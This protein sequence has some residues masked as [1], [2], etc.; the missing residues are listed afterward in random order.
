M[1]IPLDELL[2]ATRL[3]RGGRLAEATAAIQRALGIGAQKTA[4]KD[5]DVIDMPSRVVGADGEL[6]HAQPPVQDKP[7]AE[8]DLPS[9]FDEHSFAFAGNRYAYRLFVPTGAAANAPLPLV[10]MLHGCKQDAADFAAGTQMNA[11]GEQHKF[12]VLYPEQL[13]KSNQMGC[14]NWFEPAHQQR[15]AGEPAMIA[16]LTR[17][18]VAS[19]NADPQRVYVAGLSAGGAMA[20]LVGQLY[21]DVFAAVGV[22]SGLAPGAAKDVPSAFTAMRKGGAPSGAKAAPIPPT[23]VIHGSADKT[24]HPANS[25]Q[26]AQA[27]LASLRAA[28][29]TLD[30]TSSDHSHP[31]RDAVRTTYTA[32]DGKPMLETWRVDAAPHAWSGGDAS[33]SFT[34]PKGPS[35]SQAMLDFFLQHRKAS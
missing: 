22:H 3:T 28:G 14:W 26:L 24:V 8:R 33:G 19:H 17:Q 23:I 32:P 35:A 16:A 25:D 29:V 10:V 30:E 20:A 13:R 7:G 15:G 21:P 4:A 12:L 18:V 1:R 27:S 31:G 6:A 11:L 9:A 5:D 2:A 34:D